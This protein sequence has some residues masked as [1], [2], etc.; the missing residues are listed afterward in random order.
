MKKIILLGDSIRQIGYGPRVAEILRDRY[1]CEVFQP[2]D[3][4]RFAAYTLRMCFDYQAQMKGADVIHWNNGLWDLCDLF[5]DGAFTPMEEYVRLMV[6]IARILRSY[7]PV[8]IFA[9]TTPPSPQMWG[10]DAERI[11]AYNAAVTQAL[12]A[13]GVYIND[14][15]TPVYGDVQTMICEDLIH[16]SPKGIE[17]C[18]DQVLQAILPHLA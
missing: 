13:E 1:G 15:F 11:K 14:L 5:G 2:A 6:R 18:A 4:C 10:H 17:V 16:L 3:N 9:T 8:V 12:V 7:A